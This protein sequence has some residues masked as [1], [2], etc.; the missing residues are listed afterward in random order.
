MAQNLV[1]NSSLLYPEDI[2]LYVST[3]TTSVTA[4]SE[5]STNASWTNVGA[6]SEFTLESA[7]ASAQPASLNVEH[8]QVITKEAET[9]N[10]SIQEMYSSVI[11][12]LRGES[13]QA[14]STTLDLM[15]GTSAASL[16][17]LFSG[18]ADK[19]QPFMLFA[20]ASYADGRSRSIYYPYC[21]YVSGGAGANPKGQG[22][23][24]YNDMSFTVEARES[25]TILWTTS[26]LRGTY[27]IEMWSTQSTA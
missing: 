3:F 16:E 27:R 17:V 22:T 9:I 24:E 14:V 21:H 13:G 10:F 25:T 19:L 5:L 6:L 26:A 23:G 4:S 20:Y 1:Q 2:I 18:G 7:N 8:D 11:N 12:I 15:G